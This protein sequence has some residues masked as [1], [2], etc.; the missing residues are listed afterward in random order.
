MFLVHWTIAILFSV[1]AYL[2]LSN[3]V[4][5]FESIIKYKLVSSSVAAF[6]A[7]VLPAAMVVISIWLIIG[8]HKRATAFA[9]S[10]LLAAFFGAQASAVIRGLEIDCGC[11]GTHSELVSMQTVY[12]V[13]LLA[14]GCMATAFLADEKVTLDQGD[15]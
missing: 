5:F 4:A 13:G 6:V 12:W 8:V 9:A 14:T 2:H 10:I 7:T 3:P 1:S 15:N 11:Y